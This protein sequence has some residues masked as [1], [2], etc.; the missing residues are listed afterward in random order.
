[1]LKPFQN[2]W[3]KYL[4]TNCQCY[5]FFCGGVLG[6]IGLLG[7]NAVLFYGL[8][9]YFICG[10]A[11]IEEYLRLTGAEA[12]SWSGGLA[13]LLSGGLALLAASLTIKTM[14]NQINQIE[15]HKNDELERL[16]LA[17][18][19]VMPLT[20]SEISAFSRAFTEVLINELNKIE[21]DAIAFIINEEVKLP[22]LNYSIIDNLKSLI[23][24]SKSKLL[25]K[26]LLEI[27]SELQVLEARCEKF[28]VKG[29][30]IEVSYLMKEI[31]HSAWINVVTD[32]LFDYARFDK[33]E[34]QMPSIDHFRSFRLSNIRLMNSYDK[35]IE[36][37]EGFL[38]IFNEKDFSINF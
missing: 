28:S 5:H 32:A 22:K 16:H 34:P 6:I 27:I 13:T 29:K 11:I 35:T 18:R 20:L 23:Q 25:T 21:G 31:A 37:A 17:E 24:F 3:S 36:Y 33:N 4:K 15:K 8:V 14:Q 26:F 7:F 10:F 12:A 38:K 2:I 1:M 19:A 9:L 30:S